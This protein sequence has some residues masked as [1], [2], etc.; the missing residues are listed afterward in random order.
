MEIISGDD[1]FEKIK[2]NAF[3]SMGDI[4]YRHIIDADL[5]MNIIKT[6]QNTTLLAA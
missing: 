4:S 1:A 3:N 2:V 6:S 5:S